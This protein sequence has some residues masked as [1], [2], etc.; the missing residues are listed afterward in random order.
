MRQLILSTRH[1][2]QLKPQFP[3]LS[4]L[5]SLSASLPKISPHIYRKY[6]LFLH[7]HHLWILRNFEVWNILSVLYFLQIP[8]GYF[9]F[10][11]RSPVSCQSVFPSSNFLFINSK[12]SFVCWYKRSNNQRNVCLSYCILEQ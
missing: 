9:F 12:L 10:S 7:L 6:C 2:L 8:L 11:S 5:V 3:K 1:Y 4:T